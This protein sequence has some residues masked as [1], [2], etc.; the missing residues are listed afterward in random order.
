MKRDSVTL[1][2]DAHVGEW[3]SGVVAVKIHRKWVENIRAYL[4]NKWHDGLKYV[5]FDASDPDVTEMSVE[6]LDGK[7]TG[8]NDELPEHEAWV[9][10]AEDSVFDSWESEFRWRYGEVEVWPGYPAVIIDPETGKRSH[11]ER[12]AEHTHLYYSWKEK[13]SMEGTNRFIGTLSD[14]LFLFE[15]ERVKTGHKVSDLKR[16]LSKITDDMPDDLK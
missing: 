3:W 9:C 15:D 11:A 12:V 10:L 14:L 13:H 1:C 7:I 8:N 16:T 2:F 6:E 4:S 5:V